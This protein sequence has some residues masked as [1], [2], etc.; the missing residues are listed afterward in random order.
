MH[1]AVAG[2]AG[3]RHAGTLSTDAKIASAIRFSIVTG[4]VF[5]HSPGGREVNLTC[6][7][8][9]KPRQV[10]VQTSPP[11]SPLRLEV[12]SNGRP[13][14]ESEIRL[15]ASGAQPTGTLPVVLSPGGLAVTAGEAQSLLQQSHAGVWAWYVDPGGGDQ[16]VELDEDI[17]RVLRSLG[18]IE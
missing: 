14:P 10:V 16:R 3:K 4:D 9:S 8:D 12:S 6:V 11:G 2:R 17:R 7:S 5:E 18:Y 1:L 13:I 15:G